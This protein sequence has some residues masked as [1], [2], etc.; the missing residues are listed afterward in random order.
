MRD[1]DR[2]AILRMQE[3]AHAMRALATFTD[4]DLTRNACF[5]PA[6]ADLDSLRLQFVHLVRRSHMGQVNGHRDASP[7]GQ[8]VCICHGTL[9]AQA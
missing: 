5:H 7:P 8:A 9:E 3:I 2:P 4:Q 1:Q 6:A